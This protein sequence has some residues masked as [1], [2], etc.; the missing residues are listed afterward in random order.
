MEG[1]EKCDLL[2]N[3]IQRINGWSGDEVY[4]YLSCV[5]GIVMKGV[6]F[7]IVGVRP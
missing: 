3:T 5:F 2:I 1:E 6:V 7:F 4:L